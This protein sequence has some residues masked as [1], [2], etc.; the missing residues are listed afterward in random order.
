MWINVPTRPSISAETG[1]SLS[2]NWMSMAKNFG[3][4]LHD[5]K[6]NPGDRAL[7]V[8]PN[9][10]AFPVAFLGYLLSGVVAVAVNSALNK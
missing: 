10:F 7:I 4:I 6:V 5:K 9:D 8:L 1:R 2:G 3:R